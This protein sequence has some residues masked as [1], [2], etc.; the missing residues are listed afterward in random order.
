MKFITDPRFLVSLWRAT[1][2][3]VNANPLR[4]Q[5]DASKIAELTTLAKKDQ[6][7]LFL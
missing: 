6:S 4:I 5:L 1:D 7:H 2:F 3:C